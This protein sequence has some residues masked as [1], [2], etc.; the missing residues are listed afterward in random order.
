[1]KKGFMSMNH[2]FFM[3]WPLNWGS[4]KLWSSP[5][6]TD[7]KVRARSDPERFLEADSLVGQLTSPRGQMCFLPFDSCHV[8]CRLS[9]LLSPLWHSRVILESTIMTENPPHHFAG[10]GYQQHRTHS[11]APSEPWVKR[12]KRVLVTAERSR[13]FESNSCCE[14]DIDPTSQTASDKMLKRV[15]VAPD[16]NVVSSFRIN[17]KKNLIFNF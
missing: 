5:S 3:L 6:T 10:Q 7:F 1:M 9:A 4:Y 16:P 13:L 11:S 8:F 2:E 17:C 14:P 12:M 15:A